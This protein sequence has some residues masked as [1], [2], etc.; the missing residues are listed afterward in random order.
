MVNQCPVTPLIAGRF[1]CRGVRRISFR[2]GLE[3]MASSVAR[4][5]SG[6]GAPSG[7]Q[8]QSPWWGV[9]GTK[10]PEAESFLL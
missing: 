8:G 3:H 9:R 1:Q 2:E 4:W 5:G 7:I 10:P 6:G